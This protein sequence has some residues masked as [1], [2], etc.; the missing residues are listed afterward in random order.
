VSL[1]LDTNVFIELIRRRTPHVRRRFE[2]AL[3]RSE[4][5][6]A[7]LIVVHELLYG[8]HL[9]ADPAAQR[10][11]VRA[12]LAHVDV[13]AFDAKDMANAAQIRARLRVLGQPIGPYDALIAGQALARRWT[14]VTGNVR[15]FSR[16][17]GLKVIDWTAPETS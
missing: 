13:T 8:A 9:H 6:A 14:V 16:I 5:L 17:E 4:P 1:S 11:S 2:Q 7:S 10:D 12:V 15:E 3:T